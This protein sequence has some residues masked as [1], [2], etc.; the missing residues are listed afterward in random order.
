VIDETFAWASVARE[1]GDAKRHQHDGQSRAQRYRVPHVH[2]P[3]TQ[4]QQA[5]DRRR[6]FLGAVRVRGTRMGG[7]ERPAR[8]RGVPPRFPARHM[9]NFTA[10]VASLS[11]NLAVN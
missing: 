2:P 9:S 3:N 4:T 7:A 10:K 1:R 6:L 5:V 11:S 8:I